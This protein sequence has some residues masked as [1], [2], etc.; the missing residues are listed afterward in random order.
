MKGRR[1]G[2]RNRRER[3]RERERERIRRKERKKERKKR[4]ERE[5][6]RER[7]GRC[8]AVASLRMACDRRRL[9]KGAVGGAVVGGSKWESRTRGGFSGPS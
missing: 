3:Q 2:G 5:R 6:K 9:D 7:R 1:K 8:D 4:R